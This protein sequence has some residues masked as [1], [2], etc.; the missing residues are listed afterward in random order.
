M[1][2]RAVSRSISPVG[3]RTISVLRTLPIRALSLE[4]CPRLF[5]WSIWTLSG[6]LPAL[7]SLHLQLCTRLT[8]RGLGQIATAFPLLKDLNLHGIASITDEGI[9]VRRP[10]TADRSDLPPGGV[11]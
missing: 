10:R 11:N 5:D 8:D 6:A 9:A 4:A 3:P 7:Q 2:W 1:L